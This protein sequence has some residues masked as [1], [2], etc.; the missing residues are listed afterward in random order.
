MIFIASIFLFNFFFKK[1]EIR[2]IFAFSLILG[3]SILPEF[4]SPISVFTLTIY[5]KRFVKGDVIIKRISAIEDLGMIDV[6]CSDKTGTLTT[7][8]L[9]LEKIL[10]KDEK[11]FLELVASLSFGVSQKYLSDFSRAIMNEL[12]EETKKN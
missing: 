4:S 7:N 1:V 3:I 2:E 10:V 9:K 8:E 5:S 6:F 11:E 12:K